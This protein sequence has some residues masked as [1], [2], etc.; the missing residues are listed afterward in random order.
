MK[1][2]ASIESNLFKD[3][4]VSVTIK[5]KQ[6]D[7]IVDRD[8]QPKLDTTI[9][10]LKKLNPCFKPKSEGGSVTAGNACSV[11]DGAAMLLLMSLSEANEKNLKPLVRIVSWA[12]AGCEP[13]L[14]GVCPVY[15]IKNCVSRLGF[16]DSQKKSLKGVVLLMYKR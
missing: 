3:E 7:K 11:N 16:H 14:M 1:C 4:I 5:T 13:I 10:A 8:E 2:K 6:G 15:A 9:E 12:Q